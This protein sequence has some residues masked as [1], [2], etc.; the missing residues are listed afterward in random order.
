[1][2]TDL[3]GYD[4]VGVALDRIRTFEPEDGYY[5]AFSGGKDSCVIL[6]LVKRSGVKFD[7]H[8]SLTTVDPPELVQFI[9]KMH[10]E[11]KV[12]RPKKTMWELIV[13]NGCPP[14]RQARYCCRVL[15]E[16]GGDGRFLITGIRWEE[17]PRRKGWK[18]V[19]SCRNGGNKRFLHPIIDWTLG[20]IWGYIRD[21]KLPYCS[22]Y[23]EG[24]KRIG[25]VLCPMGTVKQRQ[26]DIARWP[27]IAKAYKRALQGAIDRKAKTDTPVKDFK[28]G[29]QYFSWWIN[30]S[31]R[32]SSKDQPTLFEDGNG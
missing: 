29:E 13:Y 19:G 10:P 31:P 3:Y 7:A 9:R 5:V 20:D 6:D 22:L 26:R 27:K 24:F 11:V 4:K 1:M 8:Y 21:R 23:N 18:M 28:T 16:T 12:D 14:L 25:C 30:D 15:K 32:V 2:T 17:S